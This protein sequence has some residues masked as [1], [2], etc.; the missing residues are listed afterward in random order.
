[1]ICFYFLLF[2]TSSAALNSLYCMEFSSVLTTDTC[3]L[4]EIR[5]S[6]ESL[7]LGDILVQLLAM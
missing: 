4:Q 7:P 3:C 2:N 1:M 6:G 5:N